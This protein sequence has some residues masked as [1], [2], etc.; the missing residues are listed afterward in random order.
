MANMVSA[1]P[2][3]VYLSHTFVVCYETR[4]LLEYSEV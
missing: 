3:F 4:L 1:D 2:P